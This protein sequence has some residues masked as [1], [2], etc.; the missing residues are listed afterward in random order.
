MVDIVIEFFVCVFITALLLTFCLVMPLKLGHNALF[1]RSNFIKLE[2]NYNPNKSMELLSVHI[3]FPMLFETITFQSCIFNPLQ[4]LVIRLASI[5]NLKNNLSDANLQVIDLAIRVRQQRNERRARRAAALHQELI[6]FQDPMMNPNHD[7]EPMIN[8]EPVD[9]QDPMINP[10]PVDDQEP[11]INP[12]PVG[13]QDP[14]GNPEP[15]VKE[16]TV[17]ADAAVKLSLIQKSKEALKLY[18]AKILQ[19][20]ELFTQC[21]FGTDDLSTVL[22]FVFFTIILLFLFGAIILILLIVPSQIGY[23][24]VTFFM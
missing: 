21:M 20:F 22:Y 12:E 15:L 11:M 17:A 9:D 1:S 24:I 23:R 3:L 14:V 5:L 4:A 8:P 19:N 10:E 7:Q 18:A 2:G 6:I 13:D 16:P